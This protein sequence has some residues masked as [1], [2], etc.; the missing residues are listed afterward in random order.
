MTEIV[1]DRNDSRKG[2]ISHSAL[3]LA[4]DAGKLAGKISRIM[5][6]DPRKDTL[7]AGVRGEIGGV[8]RHLEALAEGLGL[9][10][11]DIADENLK[12]PRTRAPRAGKKAGGRR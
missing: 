5:R 11:A 6:G 8:L 7:I 1:K 12:R 2:V 10:F 4:G 3:G 9:D